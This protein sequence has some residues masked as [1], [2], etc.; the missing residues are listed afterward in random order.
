[1]ADQSVKRRSTWRTR[2]KRERVHGGPDIGEKE[3]ME[4]QT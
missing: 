2:H 4:D 3:C 1:M